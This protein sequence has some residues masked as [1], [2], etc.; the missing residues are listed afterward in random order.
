MT[1][2]KYP[3]WNL[4]SPENRSKL[5]PL[6][7]KKLLKELKNQQDTHKIET[8]VIIEEDIAEFMSEIPNEVKGRHG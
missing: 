3:L 6:M 2:N 1:G 7:S 5:A 8:P 4:L